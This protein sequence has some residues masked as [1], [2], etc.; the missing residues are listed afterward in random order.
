MTAPERPAAYSGPTPVPPYAPR[1]GRTP[2]EAVAQPAVPPVAAARSLLVP[3]YVHP[4]LD[5]GAWRALEQAAGRLYGVVVNVA[6]GP[7]AGPPDTVVAAAARRLRAAGVRLF[8]YVDTNYAARP[9]REVARDLRRHQD[10]YGVSGVFFDRVAS[11]RDRLR[12][13]RRV[14]VAARRG[15]A[16]AVVLNPGVHPDPGYAAVADLLVTYEGSWEDYTAAAVPGWTA[17]HPPSR[18]CHLVYGVP[19]AAAARAVART[20]AGR[21]AAVHCAVP[22]GPPNPWQYVPSGAA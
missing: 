21:G 13:Y 8:G 16:R 11:G 2:P 10:W 12:Y 20:A 6:D 17:A 9:A 7:G 18:F 5:P 1:P 19:G 3:L 15:G 4:A 22:G 14:A